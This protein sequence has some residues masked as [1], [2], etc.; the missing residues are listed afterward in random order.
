MMKFNAGRDS[1]FDTN[2]Q[3]NT[4]SLG[5]PLFLLN[6][7]LFC[8]IITKKHIFKLNFLILVTKILP[9]VLLNQPIFCTEVFCHF[10][11]C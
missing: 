4:S 3:K 9:A 8:P 7:Q 10:Y 6:S 2:F 11:K 5:L 1:I